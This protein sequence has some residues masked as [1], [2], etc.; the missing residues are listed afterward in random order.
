M[1]WLRVTR[2]TPSSDSILSVEEA[3]IHLRATDE[4]DD[5]YIESLIS[6]ATNFIEGP[7]G[8]GVAVLPAQ[9]RLS[10]DN[11][12]RCFDID[13]CPVQTVDSITVDG[14]VVPT[15]AYDVDLD[16]TPARIVGS[17]APV[18]YVGNGKVKVTFT[19]GYDEVPADLKHCALLII[20]HLYENREAAV[21]GGTSMEVTE[22][23]FAVNAILNRYRA[24]GC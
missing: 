21:A 2:V 3:R 15:S 16:S 7:T 20:G 19:A 9:W 12:P 8:A 11:L 10:M 22:V 4:S 18:A 13:L 1:D 14:V 24:Y 6:T 23:P 5:A 17:Y